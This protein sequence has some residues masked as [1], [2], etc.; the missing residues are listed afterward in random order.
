MV[1]VKRDRTAANGVIEG[2][3]ENSDKKKGRK[4]VEVCRLLQESEEKSQ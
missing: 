4:F 1:K 2:T 3:E